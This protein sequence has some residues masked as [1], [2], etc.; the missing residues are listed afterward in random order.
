MPGD[1]NWATG[2]SLFGEGPETISFFEPVGERL[3]SAPRTFIQLSRALDEAEALARRADRIAIL[4]Y[5]VI[6]CAACFFA[7]IV[8]ASVF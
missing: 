3:G 1:R 4:A 6:A 8:A 5:V 7:G 2:P